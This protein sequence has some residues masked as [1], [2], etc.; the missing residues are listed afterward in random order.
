MD[1]SKI[2]QFL[3]KD[4][5]L[6]FF[7]KDGLFKTLGIEQGP[8]ILIRQLKY[9]RELVDQDHRKD[10]YENKIITENFQKSV[11]L[12]GVNLNPI[13]IWSHSYYENSDLSNATTW[14]AF[15]E[16]VAAIESTID[17]IQEITRWI[18]QEIIESIKLAVQDEKMSFLLTT[19]IVHHQKVTYYSLQDNQLH[20]NNPLKP[21]NC[22]HKREK[23]SKEKEYRFAIIFGPQLKEFLPEEFC[24]SLALKQ[25]HSYIK[26]IY[27]KSNAFTENERQLLNIHC[28]HLIRYV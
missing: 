7:N 3:C 17:N 8:S 11:D 25:I 12:I 22:F 24:L 9:Y 5:I 6:R 21:F 18:R 10:E 15:P 1:R 23:Y 19:G 4:N 28:P 27:L 2:T 26:A 14:E 13:F 16:K 20:Q